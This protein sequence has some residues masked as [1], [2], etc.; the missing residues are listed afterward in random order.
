MP[1]SQKQPEPIAPPPGSIVLASSEH[2]RYTEFTTSMLRTIK[3]WSLG[4][5]DVGIAWGTGSDITG[6]FN[7][8][9][10]MMRPQDEWVW[11]MGDDH[12]WDE[13]LLLQ[14]LQHELDVVVPNVVE[15]QAPFRPVVYSGIDGKS[16][17]GFD[18]HVVARLPA[19]GVHEVFAA[20]SAGMLI[21][22]NVIDASSEA[23][24]V[25]FER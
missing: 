25:A 8:A 20:G 6:N 23:E 10:E 21:R 2:A 17:E 16:P 19:T 12:V 22:R 18:Y 15:K 14:L 13:W 9:I 3:L 24:G 1:K 7:R 11:I 4:G 5:V